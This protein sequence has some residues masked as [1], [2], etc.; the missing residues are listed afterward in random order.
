MPCSSRSITKEYSHVHGYMLDL[1][2]KLDTKLMLYESDKCIK[3]EILFT[4]FLLTGA[5]HH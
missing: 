3:V 2:G 5:R 4:G 1:W